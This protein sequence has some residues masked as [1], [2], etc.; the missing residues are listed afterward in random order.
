MMTAATEGNLAEKSLAELISDIQQ[1]SGS[2]ALRLTRGRAKAVIYFE[3]GSTIFAISNIR[4]HRLSEF[5]KRTAAADERSF[6]G[7]SS[8]ANDEQVLAHLTKHG[9]IKAEEVS[10]VRANHVTDILR[11]VFLWTEGN[12]QFEARVRVAGDLRVSVDTSRL[13]LESTRHLPAA[14]IRAHLA[15]RDEQI[16][17][18]QQNGHSL[19]LSPGEAFVLSRVA[20]PISIKELLTLGGMPEEE[21]LRAI[22]GLRSAGLLI[23]AASSTNRGKQAGASPRVS[24]PESLEAFLARIDR[25]ADYYEMLNVDR[26]ATF[27]EVRN[28]YHGLARNYHPDR[29]HQ[30]DEALRS[31]IDSAFARIARA[32]E[33]LRDQSDRASYDEKLAAQSAATKPPE[34]GA[35]TST[36]APKVNTQKTG[37]EDR[38]EASF[39]KGLTAVKENQPQHALRLFAEAASL[40]PRRARYRA[41]YGRALINDPQTRRIAEIELQAAIA[42]EPNNISYRIA[43]AELYK[44]LG[45][46]RRAE[47]E[48]QRALVADPHSDAARKLLSTLKN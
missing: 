4:A 31:K 2:G 14:Y 7:L 37:N 33:V 41:E 32:Y 19:S 9:T 5:L 22:Y 43:L 46:R 25:A 8:D 3:D 18:T 40:E 48:L 16:Q 6:G 39:Q 34:R 29:F 21:T 23:R 17:T 11:T 36:L 47:G 10:V 13:L 20:A 45:L 24:E 42:L 15:D 44:A 35:S 27:D 38:A 1:T 12:W 30:A 28:A 26:A